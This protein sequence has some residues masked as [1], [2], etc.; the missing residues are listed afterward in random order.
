MKL[1][2]TL[3]ILFAFSFAT[4][5]SIEYTEDRVFGKENFFVVNNAKFKKPSGTHLI[6]SNSTSLIGDNIIDV[7]CTN[8]ISITDEENGNVYTN[9]SSFLSRNISSPISHINENVKIVYSPINRS[10]QIEL[11]GIYKGILNK[12]VYFKEERTNKLK[13][14]KC[15]EIVE[16]ISVFN[17]PIEYDC[18]ID[19]YK[20]KVLTE[21]DFHKE[22]MGRI[23]GLFIAAGGG[24]LY[25]NLNKELNDGETLEKFA[26]RVNGTA[27]LGYG[28]IIIGGI[29]VAVGI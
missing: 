26:D 25:S 2:Y 28:L 5:Y 16:I 12:K 13:A 10:N 19:T 11:M 21:I 18:S 22:R 3:I 1:L 14:I 24:V 15:A 27:K 23:G 6:F 17:S 29:L 8:L 20:P 4:T 9:C 7:N